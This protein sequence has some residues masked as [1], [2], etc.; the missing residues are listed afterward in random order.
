MPGNVGVV[1]LL[2]GEREPGIVTTGDVQ[3]INARGARVHTSVPWK[4]RDRLEIRMHGADF[5]VLAEVVYCQSLG[6][7]EYAVGLHFVPAE[8]APSG[9]S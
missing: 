9:A 1:A 4:P 7:A 3:N 2:Q 6:A 8:P 5:K